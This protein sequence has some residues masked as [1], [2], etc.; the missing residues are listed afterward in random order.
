M[1]KADFLDEL[2][3]AQHEAVV[4]VNGPVL[5]LAGAGTGKTRVITYRIAYMIENLGIAPHN[6][7][8]LTFTNKAANEMVVRLKGLISP[9][10]VRSVNMGTFHSICL[11]ILRKHPEEA[12][13]ST[14]F[15]IL[16]QE[17]RLK[18]V[19]E[20]MEDASLPLKQA[21]PKR[22]LALISE[23]KNSLDF[24][25]GLAPA[26]T[27]PKLAQVFTKYQHYMS[28]NHVV[29]F[30]DLLALVLR[31]FKYNRELL[32]LYID[33]FKYILVDE[34]QDTNKIQYE[35]LSMLAS[36]HSN[37]CVVGDDDQAIYGWR[38]ADVTNILNF[39][40]YFFDTKMIKLVENYRSSENILNCANKV[41]ANNTRRLGKELIATIKHNTEVE[42]QVFPRDI[43]EADYVATKIKEL[44]DNGIPASEIAV[45]YRTNSQSRNVEVAL[46]RLNIK[47]KIIGGIGFY[48]RKEI[49][50]ILSYLRVITNAFDTLSFTRAVQS[51]PRGIGPSNIQK[52]VEYAEQRNIDLLSSL[53]ELFNNN[54][55]RGRA[56]D[57]FANFI[58]ILHQ[59]HEA[60]TVKDKVIT[61]IEASEYKEYVRMDAEDEFDA[62]KR[63]EN[64]EELCNA[65]SIYEEVSQSPTLLDFLSSTSLV[66][67]QDDIEGEETVFLMTVHSAKGLEFENVFLT[68]LE[69][70][71]FPLR[72]DDENELE[73]ERRLAYVA[74]T[75]AKRNLTMTLALS[76][77]K[78]GLR[79]PA[80]PSI[81]INE[82]VD[83]RVN[84][85]AIQFNSRKEL[86]RANSG[87][88]INASKLAIEEKAGKVALGDGTIAVVGNTVNHKKFGQGK[89]VSIDYYSEIVEV[90]FDDNERKKIKNNYL[91]S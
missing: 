76:R 54:V 19:K 21:G 59:I 3:T 6:I 22:Y 41:I 4:T 57:G 20:A 7:L 14:D 51:K 24:I 18:Y 83:K 84:I 33:K 38:G 29:D 9:S 35:F 34:Y 67:S 40:R 82:A 43:E 89:I 39:N 17:D 48:Q 12:N 52:V 46:N 63:L 36:E 32:D 47:H 42:L 80:E 86:P 8:A 37:I 78:N 66:S 91:T 81:F 64:L 31:L 44:I 11:Q 28:Q 15:S 10:L 85:T 60:P 58:D 68:G 5:I 23:Y 27:L 70:G 90:E 61:A 53:S 77:T 56:R 49:K 87:V 30:D 88:G 25:D 75:R 1:A 79:T 69:N 73:E 13:L 55:I 62:R 2:N 72:L 71:L 26:E 50:D 74:I 45:L 16:D 65:A